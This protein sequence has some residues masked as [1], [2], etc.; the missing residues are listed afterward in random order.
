[1]AF[2]G[3]EFNGRSKVSFLG[4]FFDF[5]SSLAFDFYSN[6]DFLY[7]IVVAFKDIAYLFR[8]IIYNF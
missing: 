7:C 5:E 6:V 2:V 4:Q 3:L 1:M 8:D